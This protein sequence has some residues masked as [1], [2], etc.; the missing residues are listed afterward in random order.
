MNDFPLRSFYF[1]RHGE[2]DWN[3]Q[4]RIMGQKDIP[5]NSRGEE[6]A[7][8]AAKILANREI[9]QIFTSP[10]MRAKKTAEIIQKHLNDIRITID[11]RLQE[12]CF[13]EF[14]GKEKAFD[15]VIKPWKQCVKPFMGEDF[16]QFNHRVI[17]SVHDILENHLAPLI[18]SHGG[19]FDCL[20]HNLKYAVHP[21]QNGEIYFFRVPE[22]SRGMWFIYSLSDR[23]AY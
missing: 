9:N 13:G 10:L 16:I 18:V 5:L 14:E 1:V 6:Q 3:R 2:T 12:C 7:H 11:D 23:G 22:N 20:L 15:E 4:H 8:Q 19:V 21:I 17:S